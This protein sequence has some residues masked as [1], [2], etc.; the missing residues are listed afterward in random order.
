MKKKSGEKTL[1]W[2]IIMSSPGPLVVGLGLL[3]GKSSTQIADFV[4]RSAELLAII[5][6]FVVYKMTT[7]DGV[8]DEIR[9]QKLEKWANIFVGSM[10]CIAGVLMAM[11][12]I[13]SEE[14]DKGNVIPGLAIALLGVV[15]NSIFWRKYTSLYRREANALLL[16]QSRLYRAKTLVD[17]C[18]TVALLTVLFLPTSPVSYWVD[19]VGSVIVAGYLA[20]SGGYTIYEAIRR[21]KSAEGR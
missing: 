19:L 2:S 5:A 6:S 8:C 14:G 12:A 1:L 10:M 3:V 13:F 17:S 18:V 11:L 9:K 4:R 21:V 20:Y 7:K 15:A 16:V